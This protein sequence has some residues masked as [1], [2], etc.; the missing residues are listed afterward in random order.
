M[1]VF[2]RRLA[3]ARHSPI[4]QVCRPP[5]S[6][7]TNVLGWGVFR[8]APAFAAKLATYKQVFANCYPLIAKKKALYAQK[9]RFFC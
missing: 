9:L 6:P 4:K 5:R 1:F 8:N 3:A 7:C 2:N